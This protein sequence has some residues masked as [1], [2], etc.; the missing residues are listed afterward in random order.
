MPP[1]IVPEQPSDAPAKQKILALKA[2]MQDRM[3]WRKRSTP[4]SPIPFDDDTI[5]PSKEASSGVARAT[6]GNSSDYCL[7][8]RI[9][10]LV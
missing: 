8:V 4:L 9:S 1:L 6:G 5:A 10:N 2:N 3:A 7:K